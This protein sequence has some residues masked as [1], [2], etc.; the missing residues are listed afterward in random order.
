M[1]A[2]YQNHVALVRITLRKHIKDTHGLIN[3]ARSNHYHIFYFA[4]S[5]EN[6]ELKAHII[7]EKRVWPI[8]PFSQ[9]F[10]IIG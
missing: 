9:E 4:E 10:V 5:L 8:L 1:F 7:E 2:E 3:L 6:L